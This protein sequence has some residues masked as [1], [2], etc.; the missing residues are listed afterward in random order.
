MKL[1]GKLPALMI[2]DALL[3]AVALYSGHFLRFGTI[4]NAIM[5]FGVSGLCIFSAVIIFSSFMA[6]VYNQ[7]KE[8]GKKELLLHIFF[9]LVISFFLLSAIFY[10]M[11]EL[12]IGRGLFFLSLTVFAAFQY[13]WHIG[14]DV[15]LRQLGFVSR[16]LILGTGSLANEMG[17]LISS[18][19]HKYVLSGFVDCEI[20]PALVPLVNIV[21]SG[22]ELYA[23]AK[24]E[25]AHKIVVSL[26]DRRGA[27]PLKDM[28]NC[29]FSGIEVVDAP[30]MYEQVT[31]KLLIENITPSWFIFSDGFRTSFTRRIV[32][33][34]FDVLLAVCWLVLSLPIALLVALAIRLESKGPVFFRQVRIGEK[35]KKFML[36]KFRTMR[37]DAESATGAVWAQK[38][39]PR[40]TRLGKYLR[41]FRL[42][43]IPQ[44]YNVLVGDM[45]FIGPRPERPE[46]VEKLKEAIPYYSE[47]HC[48]K[49]GI[50][51]WAQ[52]KYPYGA[53][54]EDSTEKLRYDLYYIKNTSMPL[55]LLILL[56][57]SKV[58]LFGR[59]GR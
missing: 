26:S 40:V 48:V 7:D 45:S 51:G 36:Y 39:D 20:N 29:K 46:F 32:K 17:A 9:A 10:L 5:L 13:V 53:S 8:Y 24:R 59:G 1:K 21:G 27:L 42:D 16:V 4:E 6:E 47:R 52:I 31:G 3:S 23:T 2:G 44:L 35:E 41:K 58:I 12:T 30:T 43:E 28:L 54:V 50:T 34:I 25:R 57:T 49:P 38:D 15:A 33:R 14:L 56:E 55:D 19:H 18:N 37:E 11:P 22:D